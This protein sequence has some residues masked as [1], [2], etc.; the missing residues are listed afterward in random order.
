MSTQGEHAF[1]F[2]TCQVVINA[3]L[4]GAK[5]SERK[6]SVPTRFTLCTLPVA[7]VDLLAQYADIDLAY[8]LTEEQ[9]EERVPEADALIVMN[10]TQVGFG[11]G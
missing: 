7:G 4:R 6:Q 11:W 5:F 2:T 10:A 8:G 3:G 1:I 9:L